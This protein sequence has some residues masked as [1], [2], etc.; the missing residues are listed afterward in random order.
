MTGG[1]V[2]V[3]FGAPKAGALPGYASSWT[4]AGDRRPDKLEAAKHPIVGSRERSAFGSLVVVLASQGVHDKTVS[5]SRFTPIIWFQ[6]GSNEGPLNPCFLGIS[7]ADSTVLRFVN[8][9]M[10]YR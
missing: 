4:L 6:L 9:R 7:G 2:G 8:S 3:E 5:L 10:L 1:L